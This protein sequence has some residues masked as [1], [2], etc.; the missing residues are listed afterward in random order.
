MSTDPIRQLSIL[1]LDAAELSLSE[2]VCA[3]IFA[4]R[5]LDHSEGDS[6]V[7]RGRKGDGRKSSSLAVITVDHFDGSF[8]SKDVYSPVIYAHGDHDGDDH[9]HDDDDDGDRNRYGMRWSSQRVAIK[10]AYVFDRAW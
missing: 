5:S 1:S 6:T 4:S 3:K 7:L 9:Y 10:C 2:M 8:G